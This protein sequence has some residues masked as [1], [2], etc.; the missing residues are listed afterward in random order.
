MKNILTLILLMAAGISFSATQRY[1]L[2]FN[3]DPATTITLG[4][5]QIS[6]NNAEV[7][8]GVTDFGNSWASYP[9]SL[10]IYKTT[11]YMGMT[12]NFVK[13]TGLSPNTVYYFVIKDSE[14]T[15]MTNSYWLKTC[16]DVN[17]EKLSFVSGGDSRSGQTQ[18]QNSN[19][20][21]AKIRPHAVL[22]GGDLVNTPSNSSVQTWLDDWQLSIT[23]DRQMIPLVHS[24]GNHEAYGTGGPEFIEQLFDTP[25]DVYYNIKFGGNL[26]SMYT[27][28][29]EL[30]PGH[31][32]S[33]SFKRTQQTNWLTTEL[34]SDA[35]IWK[36]AQYHRPIVP[37]YSGKGEGADEFND[38]ANLFYDEGV[39]LVMESDAHVTKITEEVKPA[40]TNASGNSSAWFT[41]SGLDPDK[42]ITFTGEGAWG[43]IRTPDDL[44][45]LTIAATSMYHFTWITVTNCKIE[46][47]TIDTQSPST[48]PEHTATDLFSISTGLE[49]QIWKPTALPSGLIE[50]T[51]CNPPNSNFTADQTAFFT[52]TTV[53]FTDL[54]TNTPTSW[55]W[56]FGDLG[57][58]TSQNPSHLYSVA[59]TYNVELQTTNNDGTGTEIKIAY[60]VVSDP[61]APVADFTADNLT[62]SISQVVNFSDLST[63]NPDTWVWDF[64]DLGTSAAQNPAHTYTAA[65]FYTVI[66]NTS[67]GYGGDTET[68]TAYIEV[69]NG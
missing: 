14:G 51:K 42:G 38:W 61:V 34:N 55:A 19:R 26:F 56:N 41:S 48:V 44:H 49:A 2:M 23:S 33:S 65:G 54:S 69:Q 39:R 16:P 10:P 57:T 47:R 64:G 62:A 15:S 22:F 27:L 6:G 46:V 37:H 67:N 60:I 32:I 1:R 36:G 43:T 59:G 40:M 17:T 35:S 8:F 63:N 45:P 58:S 24:F 50:I 12:N 53:N 11:N 3:E 68:K 30:L 66:L 20:M 9:N 52:G 25:Y 28:N 29:G 21:V 4:W 7:Y 5:E 18:R 31:T 13:I